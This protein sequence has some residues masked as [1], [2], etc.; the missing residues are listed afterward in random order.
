MTQIPKKISLRQ[1][2]LFIIQAQIG[3]GVLSIPFKLSED[4]KGGSG[5]SVIVAG[6][7]TQIL[8]L[9]LWGLM[10]RYPGQNLYRIFIQFAGPFLGRL[11][12][13]LYI[14]YFIVLG[15]NIMLSAVEV[16]QRWMLQSTPKWI[17]LGLFSIM[18]LYLA[19][20]KFNV[21]ARFYTLAS[22]LFVPLILLISYG[23]TQ[24]RLEYT[25]PIFEAGF[26]GILKGAKDST[27][28]MYGFEIMLIILPLVE[29]TSKQKVFRICM[30]NVFVTLFYFFVVTTCLMVFNSEQLRIIPEPVIYLMKTLNFYIFDRAD[31]LFLPIWS[32]T[33]VC[34][35]ASYCYAASVG[36]TEMFNQ[37]N[38]RNF[39]PY[40][41]LLIYGIALV[42]V[43]P[44]A[45][46][47]LD[48]IAEYL[49][50]SFIGILPAGMMLLSFLTN[51]KAGEIPS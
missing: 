4:A 22:F 7:I 18:T 8:I 39:A 12:I 25:L 28:S 44:T 31:V 41:I 40:V 17:L 23:L 11:L 51:R 20:E 13:A 36:L 33:L 26:P 10:N 5:L 16:L 34:S 49:A 27:I 42:P 35:I 15:A 3:V 29:G 32:I 6:I 21:L 2:F 1:L 43:T 46:R 24:A 45:I 48:Q 9:M 19:R 37:K 14:G 30:A 50:Y 38:H 47:T